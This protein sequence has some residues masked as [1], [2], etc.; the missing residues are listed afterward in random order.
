MGGIVCLMIL[1]V[2]A[3]VQFDSIGRALTVSGVFFALNTLEGN[4]ISP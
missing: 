2:V 3:L 4:L 1:G